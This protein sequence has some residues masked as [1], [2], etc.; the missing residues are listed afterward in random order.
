MKS[1]SKVSAED[2][3]KSNKGSAIVF[4]PGKRDDL[5]V[6]YNK[7]IKNKADTLMFEGH[8]FLTV[9]CKYLLQNLDTLF[10]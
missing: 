8:E 2:G 5:R 3:D 4:N 1:G 7:A 6:E 10:K 9:Y